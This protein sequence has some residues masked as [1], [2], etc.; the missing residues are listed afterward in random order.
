[1]KPLLTGSHLA[2]IFMLLLATPCLAEQTNNNKQQPLSLDHAIT[3][4]MANN[5]QLAA[6]QF[7]ADAAAQ[8][9]PQAGAFS[10]PQLSIGLVNLPSGTPSLDQDPMSQVQIGISQKLP[11]FGKRGL[12]KSAAQSQADAATQTQHALQLRLQRDVKQAWWQIFYIDHA[13]T[14]LANNKLLLQQLIDTT[15]TLYK[16][17]KGQQHDVLLAQL[18]HSRLDIQTLLLKQQRIDAVI[19][20]NT[21]LNRAVESTI[22]LPANID[23]ALATKPLDDQYIQDAFVSQH[24][25][26]QLGLAHVERAQAQQQLS[27][28]SLYPDFTIMAKHGFREIRDDLNSI[29]ISMNL[30]LY[31]GQ[32]QF[33]ANNQRQAE[34]LATRRRLHDTEQQLI[35]DVSRAAARYQRVYQQAQLFKTAILPQAQQTVD[36]MLAGYQTNK[37]V[38]ANLIQAQTTLH[39]YQTQYW[40]LV[41]AAHQALAT[42]D[43]A[44]GQ[45]TIHE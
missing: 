28:K 29:Q 7:D 40:H 19:Q 39:N 12:L 34:L 11:F 24:P 44:L 4:S 31:A 14:S 37:V 3:L 25:L 43:A 9:I 45:E 42:L 30:P 8:R 27:K 33:R 13:L 10:D 15:Q 36:T 2:T 38:F 21:L 17:G 41:S 35:A 20:L 23:Y 32:K 22:I 5:P 6:A 1:M 16:V 18:E 26:H